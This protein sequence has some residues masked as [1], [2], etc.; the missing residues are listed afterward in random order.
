[1]TIFKTA[2]CWECPGREGGEGERER[3]KEKGEK[4]RGREKGEKEIE[5]GE[6]GR[7]ERE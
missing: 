5:R 1:M 3:G 2:N 4:E 6:K 7:E